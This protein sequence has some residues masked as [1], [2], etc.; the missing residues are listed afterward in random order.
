MRQFL[1]GLSALGSPR[2]RGRKVFE[3]SVQADVDRSHPPKSQKISGLMEGV[4]H[5]IS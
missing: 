2:Q 4:E 1:R 5:L 3:R